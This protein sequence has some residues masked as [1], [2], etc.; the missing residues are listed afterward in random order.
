MQKDKKLGSCLFRSE[1]FNLVKFLQ[2]GNAQF[3]GRLKST[4]AFPENPNTV[5]MITV[6]SSVVIA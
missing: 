2:L 5:F 6:V 4:W 1:Y 3:N